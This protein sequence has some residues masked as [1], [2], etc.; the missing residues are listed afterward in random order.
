MIAPSWTI[1]A[2]RR[3]PNGR[4]EFVVRLAGGREVRMRLTALA[5]AASD[6]AT[7]IQ[8]MIDSLRPLPGY[9]AN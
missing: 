5:A 8:G 1:T 3:L 4:V 6:R 2:E 9:Y 7:L